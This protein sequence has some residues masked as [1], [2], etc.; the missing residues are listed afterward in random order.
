MNA[1]L[2]PS[3]TGKLGKNSVN[4]GKDSLRRRRRTIGQLLGFFIS[5]L[6]VPHSAGNPRGAKEEDEKK[7]GTHKI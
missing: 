3:E 5:V 4:L 1:H 2:W 7:N 6:L